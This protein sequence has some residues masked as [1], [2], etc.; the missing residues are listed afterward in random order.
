VRSA[1]PWKQAFG[2][3]WSPRDW[4]ILQRLELMKT[5]LTGAQAQAVIWA[6]RCIVERV[7]MLGFAAGWL[8]ALAFCLA[9]G[10]QR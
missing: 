2:L 8:A 1:T 7:A 10:W 6:H 5:S 9:M 3:H 4:R